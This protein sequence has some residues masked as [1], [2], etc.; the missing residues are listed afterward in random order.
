MLNTSDKT[1]RCF[2]SSL[3]V[4][5]KWSSKGRRLLTR[6]AELLPREKT[7][8]ERGQTWSQELRGQGGQDIKRAARGHEPL[9]KG[10]ACPLAGKS[11]MRS[12]PAIVLQPGGQISRVQEP[13]RAICCCS[14]GTLPGGG[15][16]RPVCRE[17]GYRKSVKEEKCLKERSEHKGGMMKR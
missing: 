14:S 4:D 11:S 3:L 13:W 9:D 10:H 6:R 16:V 8:H 15:D 1:L 5:S 12:F 7:A 17:P 2:C